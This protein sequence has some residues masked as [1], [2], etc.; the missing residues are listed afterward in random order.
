LEFSVVLLNQ[1]GE[2]L[3]GISDVPSSIALRYKQAITSESLS[4]LTYSY[5]AT[6]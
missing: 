1:Y 6:H 5:K 4:E 3:S 2:T